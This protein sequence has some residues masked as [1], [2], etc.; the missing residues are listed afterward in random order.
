[1]GLD[2]SGCTRVTWA[3]AG[4]P[5]P[6][7]IQTLPTPRKGNAIGWRTGSAHDNLLP[8]SSPPPKFCN[9]S[10]LVHKYYLKSRHLVYLAEHMLTFMTEHCSAVVLASLFRSL[11]RLRKLLKSKHSACTWP[12]LSAGLSVPSPTPSLYS[13]APPPA[14][15]TRSGSCSF[16]DQPSY[17][18]PSLRCPPPSSR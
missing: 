10:H 9:H 8:P 4:L 7:H 13:R 17:C 14:V 1:M 12:Q 16:L 6:A 5:P 18:S 15:L 3:R 11:Q 2:Q